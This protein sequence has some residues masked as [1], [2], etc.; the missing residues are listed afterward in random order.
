M[1]E[2]KFISYSSKDRNKFTFPLAMFNLF[3]LFPRGFTIASTPDFLSLQ[4]GP[5]RIGCLAFGELELLDA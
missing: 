2:R 5:R 3:G 1:S 4:Y